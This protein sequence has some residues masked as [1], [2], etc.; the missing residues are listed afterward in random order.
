MKIHDLDNTTLAWRAPED[1]LWCAGPC[2]FSVVCVVGGEPDLAVKLAGKKIET[3]IKEWYLNE[4]SNK[5][6]GEERKATS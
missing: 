5:K 6:G 4:R 1:G 2:K 3:W